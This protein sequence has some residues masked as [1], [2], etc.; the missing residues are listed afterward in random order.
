MKKNKTEKIFYEEYSSP[1]G[2]LRFLATERGLSELYIKGARQ[3]GGKDLGENFIKEPKVFKKVFKLF[4][5][6]FKG[7]KV[8]FNL[9]LDITGTPFQLAVWKATKAI[10]FGSLTSYKEVAKSA[11]RPKAVRAVGGALSV[12]PLPIIIPCHRVITSNG[13]I[14][15]FSLLG[16]GGGEATK[17]ALLK[18][19]GFSL[20]LPLSSVKFK[21]P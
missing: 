12:N 17:I 3:K 18:I 15:G 11:R 13:K 2:T 19:E 8:E 7:K 4:D 5:L 21:H 9:P 14:G 16:E 20:P 6:F 1:I 10:P